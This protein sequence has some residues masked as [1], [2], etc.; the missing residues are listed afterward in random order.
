MGA[1]FYDMPIVI[2]Y[3]DDIIVFSYIDFGTHLID[4]TEVLKRLSAAGMQVN[5]EKC[6]LFQPAVTYLGFLITRDGIKPQQDKIQGI[7]NM[8]K[9]LTQK[10]VCH[11]V[12]MVNFY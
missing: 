9:P 11:F 1:L 2:I 3:M 7:L 6:F 4:V 8:A 5:P 12:G 10:D